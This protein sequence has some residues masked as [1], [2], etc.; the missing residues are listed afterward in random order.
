MSQPSRGAVG[1]GVD[2]DSPGESEGA[3]HAVLGVVICA[4]AD[5]H[6]PVDGGAAHLGK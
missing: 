3:C 1:T 5:P 6:L 4:P 2:W